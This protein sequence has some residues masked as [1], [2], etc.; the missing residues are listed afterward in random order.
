MKNSNIGLIILAFVIGVPMFLLMEHP[1]F[2]WIVF[3]PIV[4]FGIIKFIMW[5]KK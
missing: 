3:V 4:V 5:L 1:V 2:F